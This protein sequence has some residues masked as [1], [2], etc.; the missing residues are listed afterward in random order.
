MCLCMLQRQR[1]LRKQNKHKDSKDGAQDTKKHMLITKQYV[2]ANVPSQ[3]HTQHHL[4]SQRE[5]RAKAK[6]QG[7]F[8]A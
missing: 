5:S 7:K 8:D 4:Q 1:L 6:E 3:T 2:L